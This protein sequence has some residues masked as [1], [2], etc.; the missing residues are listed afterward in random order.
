MARY[1]P[2]VDIKQNSYDR[3]FIFISAALYTRVLCMGDK[4]AIDWIHSHVN[5][6]TWDI[7]PLAVT[8]CV[9]LRG[10]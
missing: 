6:D 10:P 8:I 1:L 9:G 7:R 3:C 5:E 4:H 2:F